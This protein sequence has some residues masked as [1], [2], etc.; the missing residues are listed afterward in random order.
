MPPLV[1]L[2]ELEPVVLVPPLEVDP[3][4]VPLELLPV[5]VP[6]ELP[7]VLLAPDDATVVAE[8]LL[9]L[10]APELPCVLEP[11]DTPPSQSH[12]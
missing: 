7:L 6:L 2:P 1:E 11:V 9:P 10:E 5:V 12:T 4:L 3:T 8:L